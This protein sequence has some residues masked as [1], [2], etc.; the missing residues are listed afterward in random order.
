MS[1]YPAILVGAR[2]SFGRTA[3]I[4]MRPS[5]VWPEIGTAR[6]NEIQ[7][8]IE[9]ALEEGNADGSRTSVFFGRGFD[10]CSVD[11]LI[12]FS[13][14]LE[15]LRRSPSGETTFPGFY[16]DCEIGFR[17]VDFRRGT[18]Q[19]DAVVRD[20][21]RAELG[22]GLLRVCKEVSFPGELKVSFLVDQSHLAEMSSQIGEFLRALSS[23][24]G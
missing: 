3:S 14:Q 16:R 22:Y 1:D 23:E 6:G 17:M 19:I 20:P 9:I 13:D 7:W 11:A 12:E 18:I 15:L 5:P 24:A 10:Q 2:H 8:T 4:R 21:G